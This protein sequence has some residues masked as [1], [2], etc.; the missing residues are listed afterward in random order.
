MNIDYDGEAR[1]E[2]HVERAVD[3]AEVSGVQ[4]RHIPQARKPR[5]QVY[6]FLLGHDAGV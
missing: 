6:G 1:R 3:I 2:Y 5:G 4:K